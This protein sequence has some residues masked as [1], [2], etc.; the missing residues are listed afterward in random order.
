MPRYLASVASLG[1]S[2]A[3]TDLSPYRAF[4]SA[5]TCRRV[6]RRFRIPLFGPG[7][8]S[9]FGASDDVFD[10]LP[11]LPGLSNSAGLPPISPKSPLVGPSPV[12]EQS[13]AWRGYEPFRAASV[14]SRSPERGDRA[15]NST[16]GSGNMSR[17]QARS[18]RSLSS[19]ESAVK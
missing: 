10:V 12:G 15:A 17:G 9:I 4:R 2:S 3:M 14:G 7:T 1:G 11:C 8:M 19:S 5:Y 6:S 18:G 16:A 13:N